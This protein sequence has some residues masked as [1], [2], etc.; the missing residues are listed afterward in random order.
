M[1]K[2]ILSYDRLPYQAQFDE[3][4]A[5]YNCLFSGYGGGKTYA[6]CMKLLKLS[7]INRGMAGGLLVP[8]LKMFKRDVIPTFKEILWPAGIQFKYHSADACLRIPALG[9]E[10]YVFHSEDD[11]ESIRGPNLAYGGVN[12]VTLCSEA[13]FKAFL[14]RIR[15]KA[16][17]LRQIAMS[18]TPE[19][20]N[21]AYD[22]FVA[23]PRPDTD[24]FYGDMRLNHHIAETYAEL[25]MSSYDDIM[26]QLYVEGKFVNKTA[27][28]AL[29]KFN[30]AKHVQD[31][32][33]QIPG[34]D[35]WVNVD[36]NV[37]PMAATLF[38]RMPDHPDELARLRDEHKGIAIGSHKLRGFA[39]ICIDGADTWELARQIKEK[40][41]K[42]AGKII[43]F[44]DPAGNSR[45]TS[46]LDNVTD[47]DILEGEGFDDIR[48]E[49]K[50]SVR[51]SLNATNAFLQKNLVTFDRKKCTETIKDLEQCILKPGTNQ[52]EK[53]K[54]PKRT[55][56]LDGFKNM[57]NHE[58]PI[59][60]GERQWESLRVR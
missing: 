26:T 2:H 21:W 33:V 57:I 47:I 13:A 11:G 25:L 31:N 1:G 23:D 38:N 14:A 19:G 36:F 52:L 42:K 56:W 59:A 30:R 53:K 8:T 50:I 44:P 43:L 22:M 3:S 15:I 17:P 18:G 32:V 37:A 55:H 27:G 51:E 48:Y 41:G 45:K 34:L 28:A 39:E 60:V 4:T 40:A 12:E 20:F 9:A 7:A 24:V 6:L 35:V 46:A 5:F 58:W 16:A 54:N 49:T 10:I 29:Y